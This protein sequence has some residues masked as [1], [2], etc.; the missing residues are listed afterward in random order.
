MA[1]TVSSVEHIKLYG[2]FCPSRFLLALSGKLRLQ[3]NGQTLELARIQTR[4]GAQEL[5][6][7]ENS[8][9]VH[10][11]TVAKQPPIGCTP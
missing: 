3:E 8:F 7:A 9:H 11:P 1:R 5:G 2:V 4:Q 10:A 6:A